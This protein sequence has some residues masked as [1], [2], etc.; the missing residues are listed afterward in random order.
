MNIKVPT[1]HNEAKMGDIAN[2]VI[3]FGDPLRAKFAAENFLSDAVCYNKVRNMYGFTGMYKDKKISVQGSG[4]GIPSMGIYSMELFAGYNV[5]NIIRVGTCG[6]FANPEASDMANSVKLRDVVVASSVKT[7][8]NY[9]NNF[10]TKNDIAPLCSK[11]LL[12]KLYNLSNSDIVNVKEGRIFTSDIFYKD[13]AELVKLSKEDL[14]GVEM[15]TLALYAN[16]TLTKK[17][18][19]AMYMVSDNIITGESMNSKE[20]EQGLGKV[21]K[22]ALDLAY[23]CEK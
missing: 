22:I 23:S 19:L 15:E 12:T 14:I 4:M 17:N 8:S 7:D 10:T 5:N 1:V 3:L 9:L 13:K 16:A 11:E 6:S 20:R 18:A 21:I 2:T